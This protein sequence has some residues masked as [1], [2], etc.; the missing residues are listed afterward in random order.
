MG[1]GEKPGSPGHTGYC[2]VYLGP[3]ADKKTQISFCNI[4]KSS[5]IQAHDA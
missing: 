3:A 2:V 4:S 1:L 5:V